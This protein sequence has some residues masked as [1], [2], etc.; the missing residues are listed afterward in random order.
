DARRR[1]RARLHWWRSQCRW[2]LGK[3][4]RRRRPGELRDPRRPDAGM[5]AAHLYRTGGAAAV[6]VHSPGVDRL[7]PALGRPRRRPAVLRV[8]RIV[9]RERPRARP[10]RAA[11]RTRTA[12]PAPGRSRA[13]RPAPAGAGTGPTA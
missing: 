1:G 12:G 6:G 2:A 5:V 3:L 8:T 7:R 4:S 10:A 11:A 9:A 13:A